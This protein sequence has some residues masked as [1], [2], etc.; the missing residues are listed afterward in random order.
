MAIT[1][2][3]ITYPTSSD[4]IAPLETHFANLASTADNA[5]VI[6][7]KQ[8]FTGPATTGATVDVTV[9]RTF[10]SAPYVVASVQGPAGSAS[11]AVTILGAPTTSGFVARV[12]KL[13]GSSAESLNLVWHASTYTAI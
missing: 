7:A 1:S 10:S 6:A 9:T 5:G 4:N 2:K 3:G 11:Y 13:S 8:S 12:Y